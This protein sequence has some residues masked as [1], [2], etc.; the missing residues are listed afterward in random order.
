MN[1]YA[2]PTACPGCRAP[3]EYGAPACPSCGLTLTGLTAQQ[4]FSTLQHADRLVDVLRGA[5]MAAVVTRPPVPEMTGLP[6]GLMGPPL[7]PG[8]ARPVGS[9]S[10][11]SVP[12][13]LLAL[14]AACLLVAA[15]VF[16]AV[17]WASLGVGGRTGVLVALTGTAAGLC[18]W[19][20]GRALRAAA[21]SFA[22]VF[23]GFLTLDFLGAR[24]AG[25]F[26]NLS[27]DG[28]VVVLGVVLAV[29][30]AATG[31]LGRQRPVRQLA[32]GEAGAAIGLLVAV[33]GWLG[34][35]RNDAPVELAGVL[36]GLAIALVAHRAKLGVLAIGALATAGLWWLALVGEGLSREYDAPTVGALLG[37][38]EAWPVAA[39]TAVALGLAAV[40][41]L[42][43]PARLAAAGVGT[44][45]LVVGVLIPT[46]DDSATTFAVAGL[47]ALG[48]AVAGVLFAPGRW[49][50]A[51]VG[52]MAVAGVS[53]GTVTTALLVQA[54]DRLAA[55][56]WSEEVTARLHGPNAFASPLVVVPALL[57]GLAI[58]AAVMRLFDALPAARA[59]LVPGVAVGAA[60]L[61]VTL[62]LYANPR[63][64]VVAALAAGAVAVW[65]LGR[66]TPSGA[67][68]LSALALAALA[69]ALP[70]DW[71]TAGAL[72]VAV[73]L[74]FAI[75]YADRAPARVA[76]AAASVV[77]TG[78]LLWTGG[79]LA[80]MPVVWLPV[81]V[82]ATLGAMCLARPVPAYELAA[83]PTVVLALAAA[84]PS[85]SWLAFHLT[86]AGVLV[87]ASGLYHHRRDLG[88]VGSALLFAA[89]WLR[90][91]DLGVT[92]VEAYT[93]PLAAALT[94]FGLLRMRRDDAAG[95][96]ATLTA[97]LSLAVVPSLLVAF[98]DPVS[99]RALLL[100]LGCL[101]MLA[102]GAVL[103]WSSPLLVGAGAGLLLVLWEAA[104]AQVLPQW[105]LIG[106]VGALLTVVGVTWE[107]RLRDLRLAMGYVR[108]LR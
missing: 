25:W 43:L 34:A 12:K 60:G 38:L 70:S 77:L 42:P 13:I 99:L 14:G 66:R 20:S 102:A 58:V 5:P 29:A 79:D 59:W 57:L 2:D 30:G 22:A 83:A 89:M 81:L 73:A 37:R 26:N 88:W 19:V 105:V 84:Q 4:L 101:A 50:W 47:L 86:L 96:L 1:R 95:T 27:Y 28:F 41:R 23:L 36:L 82:I 94:G 49:G 67:V 80:L 103:R 97:G 31:V 10:S 71:L 39:A 92:T 63:W 48:A 68:A 52:A 15:L 76:A 8:E 100:G 64:T 11:A 104:Y 7:E 90:L 54:A 72:G 107:Q 62:A 18:V 55:D 24:S 16:L 45:V 75:D 108:S 74:A 6:G 106:L 98:T 21:E 61:A 65:L 51:G 35:A 33:S 87:S 85:A 78:G 17:A 56:P 44:T 32:A 93:L 9:F 40:T 3:I 53:V 91:A 69:T 46:H